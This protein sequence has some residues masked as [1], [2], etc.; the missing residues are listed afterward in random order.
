MKIFSLLLTIMA[1]GNLNAQKL[2]TEIT[3]K[4]ELNWAESGFFPEQDLLFERTNKDLS[5]YIF[6]FQ[7][8]GTVVHFNA[9]SIECPVGMFTLKEGSWKI[10][11]NL[12]TLELKGE[13]IA[14]YWYWWIIRY[15]VE[16][17][18]DQLWLEVDAILKNRMLP[19]TATWEEL[20]NEKF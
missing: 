5:D 17:Y 7:K 14:D 6:D 4:W 19:A 3:G 15:K 20:M 12:L 11:N 18:K 8:D 10:E 13:K 9:L 1:L 16:A 2:N